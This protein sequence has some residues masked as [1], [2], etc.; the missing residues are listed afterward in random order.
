MPGNY[1]N[2]FQYS[3]ADPVIFIQIKECFPTKEN[4]VDEHSNAAR[5]HHPD[6]KSLP[7]SFSPL[8]VKNCLMQFLNLS[9]LQ[10]Y[11]VSATRTSFITRHHVDSS[12]L[13]ERTNQIALKA[14]TT[15]ENVTAA[16]NVGCALKEKESV[17]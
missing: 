16:A 14:H 4:F 10:I 8:V 3:K 13:T 6:D 15:V 1:L 12:N 9:V 17:T 11:L 2:Q 5:K 7:F